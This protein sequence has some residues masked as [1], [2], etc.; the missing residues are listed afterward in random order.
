MAPWYD[1]EQHGCGQPRPNHMLRWVVAV[2]AIL[3]A[4]HLMFA[5]SDIAPRT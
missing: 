5:Q 4:G 1:A 2:A 3:T